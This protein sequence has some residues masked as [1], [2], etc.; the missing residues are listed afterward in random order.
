MMATELMQPRLNRYFQGESLDKCYPLAMT[1]S[2]GLLVQMLAILGM[3]CVAFIDKQNSR[4][5][6]QQQV[7][8][9]N[10]EESAI[11]E[12]VLS[13]QRAAEEEARK[14]PILRR[15]IELGPSFSF[16]SAL[17]VFEFMCL[18]P[19]GVNL[20]LLLQT[21]FSLNSVE[22]GTIIVSLSRLRTFR[23]NAHLS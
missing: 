17:T 20:N 11:E 7:H 9:I 18:V 14:T 2:V 8:G 16:F 12:T 21:R 15:L 6:Y 4:M 1:L 22:A 5:E 10:S 13:A 19:F 3:A 23:L